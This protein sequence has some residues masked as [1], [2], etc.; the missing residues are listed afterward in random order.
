MTGACE[1]DAIVIGGGSAGLAASIAL[2]EGGVSRVL[3]VERDNALGGVL[4]QCVHD[5]FGLHVYGTSL[6]GPEYAQRWV[7]MVNASPVRIACETTV[8]ATRSLSKDDEAAGFEVDAIGAALGGHVKLRT[9]ALICA[10]GCRERTRGSLR[11]PGGRPAGIFSAGEA[12]YMV[13]VA[14]QMPGTK[15]AILGSGDIGLIMARRLTLEGAEV[16][17]VL[18]QEATG[19]LRNHVNCIQDFDIPI[20]YGW[21]LV[22][23][24]GFGQ[25]QGITVAPLDGN[26]EFDLSRREYMRVNALLLAVGLVPEREVLAGVSDDAPGL[27]ICGNARKP[28]DLVDQVTCEAIRIGLEAAAYVH[29]S[30]GGD[31]SSAGSAVSQDLRRLAALVVD[32]PKGRMADIAPVED[33][34]VTLACTVCPNG[35]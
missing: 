6:T 7:D 10:T 2:V 14:N 9:K 5:G 4:R 23:I 25:L 29:E 19:L 13:N 33:G 21:G 18:G 31:R 17:L 30:C 27:F 15:I 8:L 34:S 35:C 22:S 26:G 28:H 32:E 20:R 11:I 16:K 1:F 3:V 24:H 12:Q